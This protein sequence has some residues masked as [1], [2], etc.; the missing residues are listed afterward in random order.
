MSLVSSFPSTSAGRAYF[1]KVDTA[2]TVTYSRRTISGSWSW[3]NSLNGGG[4]FER[5]TEYHRYA[6][7]RYR[8]V[9]MTEAA[10]NACVSA[11]NALYTRTAWTNFWQSN[12]TWS[13][14]TECGRIPMANVT[15][16][17]NDDGSWDVEIDVIEDDVRYSHVNDVSD[18]KYMFNL[19]ET[20]REYDG[21]TESQ[22]NQ[23]AQD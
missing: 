1:R 12:G 17:S 22:L 11:M 20:A 5:M 19:L 21:E 13:T 3:T 7:K 18:A 15:P 16:V 14:A 10:K 6:S 2:L 4:T 9:G 8:Y 23:T